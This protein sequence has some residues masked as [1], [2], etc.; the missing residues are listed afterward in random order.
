[1]SKVTSKCWQTLWLFRLE[2][3]L[4]VD[5]FMDS[6]YYYCT[7]FNSYHLPPVLPTPLPVAKDQRELRVLS[8]WSV[9]LRSL[10][11]F[12]Y[13][14]PFFILDFFPGTKYS[15]IKAMCVLRFTCCKRV[16]LE[17]KWVTLWNTKH[18]IAACNTAQHTTTSTCATCTERCQILGQNWTWYS[19]RNVKATVQYT[20]R[21][22]WTESLRQWPL[23]LLHHRWTAGG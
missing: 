3:N 19:F 10:F 14:S 20:N 17:M 8:Y 22:A 4:L 7:A 11:F 12:F 1:M 16:F 23:F 2:H 5:P 18:L 9:E 15:Q 13:L 6:N 21:S